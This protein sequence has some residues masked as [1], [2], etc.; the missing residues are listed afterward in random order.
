M[1]KHEKNAANGDL[2]TTDARPY[3]NVDE[4]PVTTKGKVIDLVLPVVILT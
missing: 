4:T 2:Y 3:A 1:R